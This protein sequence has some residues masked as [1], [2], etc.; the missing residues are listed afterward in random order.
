MSKKI[1]NIEKMD[2]IVDGQVERV[3]IIHMESAENIP[4]IVIY[5]SD[6]D[7]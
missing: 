1:H 2:L 3:L 7:K 4:V 5:V 6:R